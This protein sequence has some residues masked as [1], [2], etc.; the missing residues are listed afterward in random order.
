M[1]TYIE[2]ST[3]DTWNTRL[4]Q[5]YSV[6]DLSYTYVVFDKNFPLSENVKELYDKFQSAYGEEHLANATKWTIS[7]T[8]LDVGSLILNQ[9]YE[10][11][12]AS[13]V[14]ME[15]QT[16]YSRTV[17]TSAGTTYTRTTYS[18]NG[19][20]YDRTT[21]TA[22]ITNG[23]TSHTAETTYSR[24]MIPV[25]TYS[26]SSNR[27]EQGCSSQS[28]DGRSGYSTKFSSRVINT[29]RTSYNEVIC[30]G[31]GARYTRTSNTAG[32]SYSYLTCTEGTTYSRTSYGASTTYSR[33][34]HGATTTYTES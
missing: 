19:T 33:T 28:N 15:A 17:N 3:F 2:L 31:A 34:Q 1:D 8:E 27:A 30:E 32:T 11:I 18:G 13:L 23:R 5:I 22:G 6:H 20:T 26:R 14:S 16:H 29:N 21:N 9:T 25:T 7:S 12:N 24:T 10:N 4:E